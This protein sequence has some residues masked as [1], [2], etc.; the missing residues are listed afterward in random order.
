M[1]IH[2]IRT[3][4]TRGKIM[5]D[6]I[7]MQVLAKHCFQE[8]LNNQ[9]IYGC[10]CLDSEVPLELKSFHFQPDSSKREDSVLHNIPEYG[11]ES[12]LN[13]DEWQQRCGARNMVETS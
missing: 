2:K 11:S 4:T 9:A 12:S 5:N 1:S 6:E 8:C 10:F 7:T 3:A 13:F